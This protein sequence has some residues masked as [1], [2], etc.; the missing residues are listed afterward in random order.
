MVKKM[1]TIIFI[2]LFIC[3]AQPNKKSKVRMIPKFRGIGPKGMDVTD[4]T[5]CDEFS[6][7]ARF[8]P[9]S[10]MDETFFT[11]YFWA[12]DISKMFLNFFVP[13]EKVSAFNL[14]L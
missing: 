12:R 5:S 2:T 1:I 11:F 10:I 6:Q 13:T 7:N 8:N 3:V 14:F 9:Y 4:S